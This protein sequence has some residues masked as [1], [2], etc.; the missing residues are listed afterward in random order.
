MECADMEL[1]RLGMCSARQS[2]F[3]LCAHQRGR[4]FDNSI[5]ERLQN[6]FKLQGHAERLPT[7]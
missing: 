5:I 1:I 6:N 4:R 2:G 7:G 3:G